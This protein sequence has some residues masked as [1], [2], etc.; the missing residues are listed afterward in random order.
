MTTFQ[1]LKTALS[2]DPLAYASLAN[3][4]SAEHL[5]INPTRTVQRLLVSAALMLG[6]MVAVFCAIAGVEGA[7]GSP[8]AEGFIVILF[9]AGSLLGLASLLHMVLNAAYAVVIQHIVIAEKEVALHSRI[10]EIAE[11][12]YLNL[13]EA[14]AFETRLNTF[15][16]EY[17]QL[18]EKI[19]GL[20]AD[21]LDLEAKLMA[22]E[23][24]RAAQ[25]PT[26][27]PAR[28]A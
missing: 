15:R 6:G 22:Q 13:N 4:I 27:S 19:H 24:E 11:A 8:E 20:E 10:E 12:Y 14:E 3:V 1:T 17:E 18:L 5:H 21:K 28:P 26:A 16:Q 2:T 9:W 23:K 7:A 25:H